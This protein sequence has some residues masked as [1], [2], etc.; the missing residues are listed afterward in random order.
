MLQKFFV[1]AMGLLSFTL[2]SAQTASVSYDTAGAS[3][4]AEEKKEP[5]LTITG[6]MDAYYKYDFAKTKANSYTSFTQTHNSFSLGMASLKLEHKGDKVG[7]VA[8]LGFGPR[9][10]DFP[11]R[12]RGSPRPS[13]N[14]MFPIHLQIGLSSHWEPGPRMWVMNYWI[15]N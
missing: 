9:A 6:S 8:D 1:A 7:A 5:V 4:P 13:N 15:L 10:R 12:M 11:T 14:F 2:V 3:S